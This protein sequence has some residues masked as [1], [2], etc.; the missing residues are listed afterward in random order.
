MAVLGTLL[1]NRR[2]GDT[3]SAWTLASLQGP[4]TLSLTSPAF[5]DGGPIPLEHAAT[6]IGGRNV[7]PG[8]SWS[9]PPAGT[10]ELLLVVED[11]DVPVAKRSCTASR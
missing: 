11:L 10:T 1:K 3:H 9:A 7:S 8:L 4:E 6:R 5:D 2:C